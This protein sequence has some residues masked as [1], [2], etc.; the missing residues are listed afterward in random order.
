MK[1]G[2]SI[3]AACVVCD[4]S[5]TLRNIEALREA[6]L[7]GFA[8]AGSIEVDASA[9]SE[10]DLSFVQLI[11][12]A[13]THAAHEDKSIHLTKPANSALAALLNRAGLL[14]ESKADDIDFWFH[15]D[16]PQ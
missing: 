1:D 6:L 12:T 2:A 16:L 8:Q 9:V 10:V 7:D 14:T 13:R 4:A 5:V 11:E 3:G 15:G